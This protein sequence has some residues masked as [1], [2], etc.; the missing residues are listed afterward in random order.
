MF[1]FETSC[2]IPYGIYLLLG[3]VGPDRIFF[4]SDAPITNPLQI[5]IDKIR[6]LPV[7]EDVKQKIFYQNADRFFYPL[8]EKT[9]GLLS[10]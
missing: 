8:R 1:F 6:S 10:L 2:S 9:T 7:S 5:E 3:M 4:G